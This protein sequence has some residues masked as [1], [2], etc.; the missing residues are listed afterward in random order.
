MPKSKKKSVL[1]FAPHHDDEA[2][3]CGGQIRI[4]SNT[5]DEVNLA[6]VTSGKMGVSGVTETES[7][8]IREKE[9]RAA[10]RSLGIKGIVF[11][12]FPDHA[13]E[14]NEET[15]DAFIKVVRD[16]Q[17]D[18]IYLPHIA[19]SDRDHRLT[20]ELGKDAAWMAR[21]STVSRDIG[22]LRTARTELRH[23][24]VWTPIS[25]PRLYTSIDAVWRYKRLAIECYQTQLAGTD[26]VSMA[27]G[28][29]M[30]RA[31]Q[32]NT[33]GRLAESFEI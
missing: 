32:K 11:L 16:T 23:Y 27:K 13:L 18:I 10:A 21:D 5:G 12:G 25:R 1:V 19:E 24:E 9:T 30:Y 3:G 6:V 7:M 31:I 8:R 20:C 22:I 29:N 14:F 15:R 26:Y 33:G 28:L 4:H 17:P 2:I